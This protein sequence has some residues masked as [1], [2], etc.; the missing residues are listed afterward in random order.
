MCNFSIAYSRYVTD[1]VVLSDIKIKQIDAEQ[2]SVI[3]ASLIYAYGLSST[4]RY[5][6]KADRDAEPNSEI[7]ASLRYA[8]YG[9]SSTL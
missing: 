6:N 9:L 4:L 3:S 7:S 1:S 2:N 5:I 8:L